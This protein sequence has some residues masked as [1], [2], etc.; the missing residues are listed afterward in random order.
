MAVLTILDGVRMAQ[1]FRQMSLLSRRSPPQMHLPTTATTATATATGN[2][3]QRLFATEFAA[4]LPETIIDYQSDD[5]YGRGDMH[6]S[7]AVSEGDTIVYRTG[8]WYVDGVLVGE[9]DAVPAY[10]ICRIET[11]QIVWTHNC[12]H[13]VLRGLVVDLLRGETNDGNDGE[14][15]QHQNMSLR[16]PLED[17]EFGPEQIIARICN[18]MWEPNGHDDEEIGTCSISLHPSMWKEHDANSNGDIEQ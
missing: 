10:E 15:G 14:P 17:V 4:H 6:L 1:S 18:V 3:V 8:S 2:R 16:T 7:A 11:I 5:Y 12:E 13:G 9:E